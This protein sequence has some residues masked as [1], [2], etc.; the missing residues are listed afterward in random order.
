MEVG[1]A[2]VGEDGQW[3][4]YTEKDVA[5]TLDEALQEVR[6]YGHIFV[7]AMAERGLDTGDASDLIQ[8]LSGYEALN[9]KGVS[10]ILDEAVDMIKDEV[11]QGVRERL[12]ELD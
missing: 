8:G 7:V 11:Y 4:Y 5:M 12:K 1:Q 3:Y 6:E 2:Y 10:S 9:M